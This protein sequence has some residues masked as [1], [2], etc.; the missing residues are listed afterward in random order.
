MRGT[1]DLLDRLLREDFG[2]AL[3][4]GVVLLNKTSGLDRADQVIVDGRVIGLLSFDPV[5]RAHSFSPSAAG[6][7]M[8]ISAGA[9]RALLEDSPARGHIKG[10]RI[11][12]GSIRDPDEVISRASSAGRFG[13]GAGRARVL[14][15][16][17]SLVAV[18]EPVVEGGGVRIRDAGPA[19]LRFSGRA[20]TLERAAEASRAWL[21]ALEGRAV[22]EILSVAGERPGLPMAVSFS[23]G[24]DSLAAL[25]LAMRASRASRGG[26]GPG[27]PGPEAGAV[28]LGSGGEPLVLFSN[29]GIEFPE[30][31]DYVRRLSRDLGLTL[32]EESAGGAFWQNLPRFGPPAKDFRWCCKVCKLAPMTA[33]VSR[34][35]PGGVLTVEGRRWRESF[36]RQRIRLV[37]ESPFVPGQV[38][39]EPIRGWTAL[40]VWL[41]ILWRGLPYNPLYD[42]DLERVGC[43]LCPSTL[44]SE[45]EVVGRIHPELSALWRRKLV[46]EWGRCASGGN[47]GAGEGAGGG[48]GAPSAGLAGESMEGGG[49]GAGG[50]GGESAAEGPRRT[51]AEGGSEAG[52]GSGER[53][54]AIL[55]GVWRWRSPPPKI[56]ALAEREGWRLPGTGTSPARL[57]VTGAGQPCVTGGLSLEAIL[58][59]PAPLERLANMLLTVGEVRVSEEL[60]VAVVKGRGGSAKLFESGH[61]V[62]TNFAGRP[63]PSGRRGMYRGEVRETPPPL[64]GGGIT[65]KR[66]R[67][68]ETLLLDVVGAALR[69]SQC[70]ACGI[71]ERACPRGAIRVGNFAVVDEDRCTHCLKCAEGCVLVHYASELVRGPGPASLNA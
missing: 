11:P 33:L 67:G 23:G 15:A 59:P 35:F 43:W 45:L 57:T 29:T 34:E 65:G 7:S 1:R 36:A 44:E 12:P 56:R 27:G 8:L 37:E 26:R 70:A 18:G 30:T 28:G 3:P 69:A 68:L 20:G 2:V 58:S 24:K 55:A 60:G 42:E 62:V 51:V 40:E 25:A 9:P 4:A 39:V 21:E 53:E 41:Y 16:G 71:C 64:W 54:R 13:P 47:V 32:L 63:R 10:K 38:N 61:V 31:V 46:E 19:G 66:L 5:T 52:Q 48:A 50:M 17:S 22:R 6:A 49:R 14:L